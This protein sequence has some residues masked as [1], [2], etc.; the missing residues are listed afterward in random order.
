[1]AVERPTYSV[2]MSTPPYEIRDYAPMLVAA[3]HVGGDRSDAVSA[4]FRLLAKYIFGDNRARDKIP[5]TAP[6]MQTPG[7]VIAMTAPVEQRST[8][9]GWEVRFTMPA[10]YTLNTLPLPNDARIHILQVPRQRMAVV[11]FSGFWTDANLQ[12]HA[13]QL[14]EWVTAQRLTALSAPT[15]AYYDPPWTPWFLRTIEVLVEIAP[16]RPT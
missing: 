16:A 7:H 12:S 2:E 5:M 15:Y 1:M 6:V 13:A 14:L 9:T 3:V 8:E 10:A 4:G 11:K